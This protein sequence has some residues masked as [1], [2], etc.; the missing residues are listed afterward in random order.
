M[1]SIFEEGSLKSK[2]NYMLESL[3]NIVFMHCAN[4]RTISILVSFEPGIDL[5][6]ILRCEPNSVSD[7]RMSQNLSEA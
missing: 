5:P 1:W 6:Q 4:I 2:H 3:R 7:S